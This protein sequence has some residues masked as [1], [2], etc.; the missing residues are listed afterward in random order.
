[1]RYQITHTTS[2][3]YALDVGRCYNLA[4][5]IPRDTARQSC[6]QSKVTVQPTPAH[7]NK[8][9]DYFGN[10]AYYFA[11]QKPHR[12]L[13]I[14]ANSE[15]LMTPLAP[16][17]DL[18]GG[19]RCDEALERLQTEKSPDLLLA[20]EYVLDSPMIRA[21][22]S[23]RDYAAPLFAPE[24]PLLAAALELTQNIF[25]DFTYDPGFTT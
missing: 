17:V 4:H 1:V 7:S 3:R 14:T 20:R 24:R 21:N 25:R 5:V 15:V 6:T 18:D 16:A 19:M 9:Q 23:L 11:I 22:E 10:T 13:S 12:S 8:R 2:Y